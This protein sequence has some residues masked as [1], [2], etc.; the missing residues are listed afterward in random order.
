MSS[1]SEDP[2][3][4][5]FRVF[6]RERHTNLG[7]VVRLSCLED[8]LVP[9]PTLGQGGDTTM[10][11]LLEMLR[12]DYLV[13]SAA[14]A[15]GI[16][17]DMNPKRLIFI[18]KVAKKDRSMEYRHEYFEIAGSGDKID[19]VGGITGMGLFL[20][21]VRGG[22][23]GGGAAAAAGAAGRFSHIMPMS[24]GGNKCGLCGQ[25]LHH[26]SANCPFK[27]YDNPRVEGAA[28]VQ[29]YFKG[30]RGGGGGGGGGG[31]SGS[32]AG[33]GISWG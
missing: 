3:L 9:A 11:D 23:G 1:E 6:C 27:G 25:S 24:E 13:R 26:N 22:G 14:A 20:D 19:E 4:T 18:Y 31:G 15:L 16:D 7:E 28:Y 21:A 5:A 33:G 17:L 8:N 32:G 10:A 29:T 12:R 30:G 2:M